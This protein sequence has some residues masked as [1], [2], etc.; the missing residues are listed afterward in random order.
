[1]ITKNE[2]KRKNSNRFSDDQNSSWTET[3]G[4]DSAAIRLGPWT[5]T[6]LQAEKA[7]NSWNE[8]RRCNRQHV[9]WNSFGKCE[10][11]ERVRAR[12]NEW[13]KRSGGSSENEDGRSTKNED[14]ERESGLH[15][16]AT[17][18]VWESETKMQSTSDQQHFKSR[19]KKKIKDCKTIVSVCSVES[20]CSG[21][22]SQRPIRS[23]SI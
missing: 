7:T 19:K 2:K 20:G 15:C 13:A 12:L 21:C 6:D 1:M 3:D 5:A 14:R 23:H 9:A 11:D 16:I 22:W 17:C 18:F 10:P 8:R 4:F